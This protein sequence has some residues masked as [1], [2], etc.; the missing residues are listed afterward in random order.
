[1]KKKSIDF[2]KFSSIKV[3]ATKEVSIIEDIGEYK[4]YNIIG[5]ASNTLVTQ[6]ASQLAILS[7]KFDYIRIEKNKLIIGGA[8]PSGKVFS[9]CK[10]YNIANFEYLSKLPGTLGAIIKINAGMKKY[11]VANTLISI[12]TIQ[13]IILKNELDFGYRYSNINHIVYEAT[14]DI[15]YGFSI[16]RLNLFNQMRLNQPKEPSIGSIFKNP[17]NNYAGRLIESVGLK[18]YKIGNVGWSNIHANFI[19]NYGSGKPDD[20]MTLISLAQERVRNRFDIKLEL[21]IVVI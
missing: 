3:G 21:E 2:S 11:E 16:D 8:T 18:G 13:G 4:E 19:V 17:I 9:F 7:K 10:K 14:F 5:S 15:E 6:Q 12:R 1:M 20:I